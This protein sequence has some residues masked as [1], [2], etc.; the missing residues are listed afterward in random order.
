VDEIRVLLVDDDAE[1]LVLTKAMLGKVEHVQY[2][3]DLCTDPHEAIEKT[4]SGDYHVC[5]VDYNLG[6]STGLDLIEE[7]MARGCCRIPII[8]MTGEGNHDIDMQAMNLGAMDYLNKGSL[9]KNILERSIRYSMERK[10]TEE[11]LREMSL[12]DSLTGL[13]NRRHFDEV[14]DRELRRANREVSP[15]SL[16]LIDIDCFKPFNDNYGHVEGDRC[17]QLVSDAIAGCIS[18][19]GDLEARYGGEE[20]AVILPQ[21]KSQDAMALAEKMRKA[22]EALKIPHKGST[23]EASNDLT[24]SAGVAT[25]N[26]KEH[27]SPTDLI[28]KADKALYEAK[29]KG[30]NRVLS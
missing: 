17:L 2:R 6:A 16:V 11:K 28:K 26:G 4:I 10:K 24:I 15:I 22:I 9:N 29:E 20:L 18:R 19:P 13:A 30:R 14:L 12:R 23:V 8:L 1:E 3:I 7:V 5:L 21:T 27:L 25:T